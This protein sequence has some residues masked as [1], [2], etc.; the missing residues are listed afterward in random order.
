LA[1][2]NSQFFL[3]ILGCVLLGV[4]NGT[5]QYYRFA[6]VES[7]SPG[8]QGNAISMTLAGGIIAAF[9][10]PNLARF[11]RDLL[12]PSFTASFVALLA[13]ALLSIFF[14]SLLRLPALPQAAAGEAR[15]L[16]EIA[17]Q[18]AFIVAVLAALLA[19]P[20]MSLVMT[21]TPLA[22]SMCGLGFGETATVLQWHLV[23]MFTP[24]LFSGQLIRR[25]GAVRVIGAGCMSYIVCVGINLRGV[26]IAHF[27][28]GLIMLGLGWNLLY[29]GATSL[30]TQTYGAAERAKVQAFNDTI[31]FSL[32]SCAALAA[33]GVINRFGWEFVNLALLPAIG[34]MLMAL[35]WLLAQQRNAMA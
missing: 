29:V 12:A 24:S 28:F 35:V 6:A 7:V 19:W 11:T 22:M 2:Y 1:I 34:L 26:S 18:P 33:A 20:G 31:V 21:A 9:L 4:F 3:F 5:G 17:R 13:V 23:A 10:G 27:E 8:Q 32:T 16:S 30:L 14:C 15:P 25:F